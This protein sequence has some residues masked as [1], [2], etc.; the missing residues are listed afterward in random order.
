M[1]SISKAAALSCGKLLFTNLSVCA[2]GN[3]PGRR[4]AAAAPRSAKPAE[5]PTVLPQPELTGEEPLVPDEEPS[6]VEE[7]FSDEEEEDSGGVT[8]PALKVAY[9][10]VS[11]LTTKL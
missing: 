8:A 3:V 10:S 2:A 7:S 9:T 11:P 5:I 4:S 1:F 6:C